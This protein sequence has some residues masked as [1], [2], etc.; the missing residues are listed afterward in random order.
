MRYLWLTWIDPEPEHDGQR[1]YSGR[2]IDAVAA[3]GAEIDVLCFASE[4]S[5]RQPGVRE[6]QICWWPVPAG[7]KGYWTSILSSLP[8]VASRCNPPQKRQM[9]RLLLAR[10]GWDTIVLDGLYAGWA[11]PLL[12]EILADAKRPRLV[13]IAHNHE[14]SMR[15]GIARLHRGSPLVKLLLHHDAAK[16][17][18]VE[19]RMV[20]RSDVVTAITPEDAERFLSRRPDRRV[21]VLSPGYGGP[22]IEK[23]VIGSD[24]PRR[25]L[26]VGSFGWLAKRLNL[27]G[28]LAVADPLLAEAG[29]QLQVVGDGDPAFL[30]GLR[31]RLRATDVVGR[32]DS[33]QP[34]LADARLAVVPEERGGGFKLKIL[35]Y[36]F[37][38][39]P[40]VALDGSVAGT[41]LSA[42][43][44]LLTF[45]TVE[46]LVRGGITALDDLPLLNRL[47]EKAYAACAN[48]FDWHHRGEQFLMETAA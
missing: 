15:A 47:Q 26:L 14:E 8:N 25:L 20:D 34:Y 39:L 17:R 42:P 29:A 19:R 28:F 12:E 38:R 11:L 30:Q 32:V 33:V 21:V 7:S 43:E 46:D 13:Y 6:G 45:S 41:P 23:R 18:R 1:I 22:R 5:S 24:T 9:L 31:Q 2:L 4:G 44:S 48:R 36:V 27:E 35:D 37:N 10:K 3:A 40:V 16:V